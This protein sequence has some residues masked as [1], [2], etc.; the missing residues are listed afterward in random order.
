MNLI[1]VTVVGTRI[2]G[3]SFRTMAQNCLPQEYLGE[4]ASVKDMGGWLHII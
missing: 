2:V 1:N 3:T 4:K